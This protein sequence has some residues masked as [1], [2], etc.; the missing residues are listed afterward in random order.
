MSKN[1]KQNH[2]QPYHPRKNPE[3]TDPITADAVK[4]IF[5]DSDDFEIREIYAGA[6][7]SLKAT[8]FYVDGTINTADV[9][10]QIVMPLTDI[11]R[12]DP[13]ID[14][15]ECAESL[16]KGAIFSATARK[17]DTL[18]DLIGDLTR[19]YAAVVFDN[20][21]LAVTFE[22]RTSFWRS[23]SEPK[24]EKS[25]KGSKDCFVESIRVNTS[26]IRRKL[27][28][29]ALKIKQ[30]VVGRKSRTTVAILYVDGVCNPDYYNDV[31]K[32]IDEIDIDALLTCGA[33]VEQ[34]SESPSSPF[35]Q[36]IQTERP[37]KFAMNLL[38]G[39]VG[40]LVDGLPM[41]YLLPASLS[42]FV[43]VP[44]DD[45]Y[46]YIVASF[47]TFLRYVGIVTTILLPGL[48]IAVALYHQEM[49]PT[50]LL[51]SI[52]DSKKDVPFSTFMEIIG[53]LIAF[54][55]LQ[56]AGLRLPDPVGQTV[57]IIGALIVGQSAVE[58]RVVSPIAVIVVAFAGI[59]GYTCPNPDLSTAL[60]VSR[61]LVTFAGFFGG[62]F[63]IMSAI[64]ILIWHLSSID[65]LGLSYLSPISD[66]SP[67]GWIRTLGRPPLKDIKYRERG[68]HTPDK[69]TQK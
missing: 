50:K 56:E 23:I 53:M 18:D 37:D 24:M 36:M 45:A 52:I 49:I 7:S 63:G 16:F 30:S 31:L 12:V 8:I 9:S 20:A 14:E 51:M 38:E 59:A 61:I 28:N 68:L 15:A 67:K 44:E 33:L 10:K 46:H 58:A 60:R 19:G 26:L 62:M 17:R 2:N 66:G 13:D 34:L 43:K 32:R 22:A 55:L 69:R 25:V 1:K 29:P 57:S 65:S 40:I 39:R 11:F 6:T 35:P 4:A 54:E 27:Y 3:Y 21:H 47:M 64:A 5:S 48:Y 41:G 42:Q